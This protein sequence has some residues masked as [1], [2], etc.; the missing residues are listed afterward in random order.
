M[1]KRIAVS[2]LNA[3]TIDILNTIRE[4]ASY[5][6]QSLV[7]TVTTA[8]DIPKVGEVLFGYPSMANEFVNALVNRIAAYRITSKVY[9]NPLVELKKVCWNSGRLSK[10]YSSALRKPGSFLWKKLTSVS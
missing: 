2:T 9:N 4:N 5:Q 8:T 3:S 10:K 6:Y 7:P 1:A